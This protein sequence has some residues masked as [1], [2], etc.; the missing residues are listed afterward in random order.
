M[1]SPKLHGWLDYITAIFFAVAPS[2]F[3][4]SETATIICYILAAV[5]LLMT[6]I[7]ALPLS[8]ANYIPFQ[9]HGYVELIVSLVLIIGPWLLSDF[10]TRIDQLFFTIVGA[11]IFV[12]WV[13][14]GYKNTEN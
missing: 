3:A 11:V 9:I 5:H 6:L 1:L 8:V 14:T 7:T 12:V 4:L 2:I 10:F 13:L